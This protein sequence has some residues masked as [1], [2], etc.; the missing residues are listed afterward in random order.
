M[1]SSFQDTIQDTFEDYTIQKLNIKNQF[2]PA[3]AHTA[4]CPWLA[5]A[6][7]WSERGITSEILV[8]IILPITRGLQLPRSLAQVTRLPWYTRLYCEH[9]RRLY[10]SHHQQAGAVI[11]YCI[12]CPS[13]P[14]TVRCTLC[15]DR[16]HTHTIQYNT[17]QHNTIRWKVRRLSQQ[18]IN[19]SW[20]LEI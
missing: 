5:A 2:V 11:K 3:A 9:R 15:D 7:C 1:L 10:L 13:T 19:C 16:A 14:Y 8:E 20:C 12:L 17:I 6:Y 4:A 18:I